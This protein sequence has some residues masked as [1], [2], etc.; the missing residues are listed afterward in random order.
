MAIALVTYASGPRIS[1]GWGPITFY[2][3][4]G[5]TTGDL[6]LITGHCDDTTRTI[7][8]GRADY[9]TPAATSVNCAYETAQFNPVDNAKSRFGISI[10]AY[11][12]GD[13]RFF[14][15]PLA[16]GAGDLSGNECGI[17]YAVHLTG[18]KTGANPINAAVCDVGTEANGT[19]RHL[20]ITTTVNN[21]ALVAVC[22]CPT[23]PAHVSG[24]PGDDLTLTA[25]GSTFYAQSRGSFLADAGAFGVKTVKFETGNNQAIIGIVALEPA[26][27][28]ASQAP[29]TRHL[30]NMMGA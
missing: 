14:G 13:D 5:P 27:A 22:F 3:G 15:Y 7:G 11:T 16:G 30:L 21:C 1:A 25:I 26:V 28:A 12:N 2:N 20:T 6:W 24:D 18:V 9:T 19:E 29:R 4:G 17:L 8:G 10:D 23:L